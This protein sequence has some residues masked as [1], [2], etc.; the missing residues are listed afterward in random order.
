MHNI[1][2]IT[3]HWQPKKFNVNLLRPNTGIERDGHMSSGK[4]FGVGIRAA[5]KEA[6]RVSELYNAEIE[7]NTK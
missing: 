2:T 5:K 7:D 4:A 1:V 6:K 3:K